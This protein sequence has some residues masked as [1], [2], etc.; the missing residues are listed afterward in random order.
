MNLLISNLNQKYSDYL[1]RHKIIKGF[2]SISIY[3]P[4]KKLLK[5]CIADYHLT[6]KRSCAVIINE[7]R[8]IIEYDIEVKE[9]ATKNKLR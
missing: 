9:F 2:I 5:N 3:T 1:I 6:M 8:G 7:I 4:S